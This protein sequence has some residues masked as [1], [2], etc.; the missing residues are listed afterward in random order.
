MEPVTSKFKTKPYKHQLEC[1][2]K[3]GRAQAFALLADMGT[4]KTWIIINNVADLWSSGDCDAMIVLAPN[5]VHSNWTRLELPKHMP[6]W[7]R[8]SAASW[9]SSPNKAEKQALQD[10]FTSNGELRILTMNWEALQTKR[11]LEFAK[12]FSVCSSKLMIVCDESDSIK[13]PSTARYKALMQLR[14]HSTWRRIM[15]GTPI[16]NA[17]F[18]AFAQFNFLDEHILGTTSFY[19]FKAEYAEMLHDGHPLLERIKTKVG[20]R[21]SPQIVARSSNGRPRYRNL[22]KLSRLIAPHSFRVTK[23]E[24]LDLPEKIYK[25]V[26]FDL[27]QQQ[28]EVY[29][30]AEQDCRL[31][32]ENNDAPFNKLVAVTKLAQITSGYYIH[33]MASEPVRIE[34]DNPKLDMLVNRVKAV[35]D[36]GD[37]TIV[38]ARYS[39]EIQDIVQK[40]R[41]EGLHVVEYHGTVS[42]ADRQAAIDAFEHGEAQVFVG[43]QQAGG[44]GITLVAA[45]TVIYFSN[46]FSL[47][48][49]LQSE[50]RAHRIGQGRSVN[51]I[52]IAAKGTIDESVIRILM[53][54]Q[55]VA[56]A[57]VSFKSFSELLAT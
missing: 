18:D 52:N 21:R 32:F 57:I 4:G 15:T 44:T 54:K 28:K 41:E 34:G 53:N 14:P 26:F 42:R 38:W 11:G 17:P 35:S 6:D 36:A 25:T 23:A 46:N 29:K 27:T 8:Y 40:L 7:V 33:P 2:N 37:K 51:Y 56:D 10:V 20:T 13:N 3:F 30:K 9:V 50:D 1:L 16:N 31:A 24:C 47:R 19:A 45:S 5:G 39:V 49:R 55:E 48:D 12:K 22:D 43:N